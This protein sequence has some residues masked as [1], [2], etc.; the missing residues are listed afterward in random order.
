LDST[1]SL[2][3]NV[4]LCEPSA[5]ALIQSFPQPLEERSPGRRIGNAHHVEQF[6]VLFRCF[7]SGDIRPGIV[8]GNSL[9]KGK[10]KHANVIANFQSH[11]FE[12]NRETQPM[13]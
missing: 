4:A 6:P 2:C 10:K 12:T 7:S 8:S 5:A 3:Q 13:I 9:S 11:F 1:R